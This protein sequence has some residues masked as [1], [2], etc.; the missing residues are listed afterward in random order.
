MT[1]NTG[2]Q[3]AIKPRRRSLRLAHYDYSHAGAYFVTV[4]TNGRKCLF[5]RAIEDVISLNDIGRMVGTVWNDI[6]KYYPDV[7]VDAFVTMP[8]HIHGIIILGVGA[9]PRACPDEK[10]RTGQPRGVAP[11]IS[12]PDVVQRF[13]SL[14]TAKYIKGIAQNNWPPFQ[15]RLWQ[16]NY[17]EHVVRN[18]NELNSIREY[19]ELNPTKWVFDREN[20]DHPPGAQVPGSQKEIEKI[21]GCLP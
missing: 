14:T 7:K 9:G 11:T 2:A 1:G 4:C 15:A 6:P 8:N 16:R 12:L 21:L 17:Y 19:I 5:G 3:L 18:E 10:Q 20:P 13:K